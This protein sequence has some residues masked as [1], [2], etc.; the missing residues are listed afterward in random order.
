LTALLFAAYVLI[1]IV[2]YISWKNHYQSGG[3]LI[4]A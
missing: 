1:A 4:E 3:V 2:G